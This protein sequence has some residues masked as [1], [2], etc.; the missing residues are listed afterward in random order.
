M[1]NFYR[2]IDAVK[3]L[4]EAFR[5]ASVSFKEAATALQ[6]LN[7]AFDKII[8]QEYKNMMLKLKMLKN[9]LA[10]LEGRQSECENIRKKIRR[11]IRNLE[12]AIAA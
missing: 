4:E 2:V 5:L 12:A 8:P 3:P 6:E 10:L 7:I 9:R 11:Q 1:T